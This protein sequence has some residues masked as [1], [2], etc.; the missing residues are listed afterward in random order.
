VGQL[1]AH[2]RLSRAQKMGRSQPTSMALWAAPARTLHGAP[3]T[4]VS[5]FYCV[6]CNYLPQAKNAADALREA[7]GIEAVLIRGHS[8]RFEV[9]VDGSVVIAKGKSG[10]PTSREVV[11][12]VARALGRLQNI[13]H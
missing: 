10:F 12:A 5:I 3:L 1:S 6:T 9:E 8:G 11:E 7:L 13:A 2:G 4:M